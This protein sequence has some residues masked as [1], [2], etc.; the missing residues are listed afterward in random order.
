MKRFLSQGSLTATSFAL[1]LGCASG[2]QQPAADNSR[3]GAEREAAGDPVDVIIRMHVP[4]LK[5]A[6][7]GDGGVALQIRSDR[8]L[9]GTEAPLFLLNDSPYEPG[10][11]GALTGINPA[12]IATIKVLTG[13][14]AAIYGSRGFNGVILITTKKPGISNH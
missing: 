9:D 11:G 10:P 5:V 3:V 1:A 4:G 6:R 8:S 14:D 7:T 13:P 2:N 12:D